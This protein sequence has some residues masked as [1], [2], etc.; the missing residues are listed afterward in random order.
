[1]QE[2]PNTL[3]LYLDPNPRRYQDL[4]PDPFP[5][6][7]TLARWQHPGKVALAVAFLESQIESIAWVTLSSGHRT[8]TRQ[9]A[10]Q[11]VTSK[12]SHSLDVARGETLR[13]SLSWNSGCEASGFRVGLLGWAQA[14]LTRL[15]SCIIS[16]RSIMVLGFRVQGN[17]K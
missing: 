16:Y 6:A 15:S 1:M 7:Q 2:Q 13:K 12:T 5:E 10:I 9:Q 4:G 14:E 8:L 17:L 3:K 11:K